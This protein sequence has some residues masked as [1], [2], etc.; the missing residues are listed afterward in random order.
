M[1]SYLD[2]TISGIERVDPLHREL[3]VWY[4]A[5]GYIFGTIPR[6]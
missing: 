2:I 3:Q 6:R 1:D 4:G 5:Y